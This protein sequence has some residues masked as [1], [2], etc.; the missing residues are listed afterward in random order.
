[1][2]QR[3]AGRPAWHMQPPTEANC[4]PT[5]GDDQSHC[6]KGGGHVVA[7]PGWPAGLGEVGRPHMEAP[8]ARVWRGNQAQLYYLLSTDATCSN[9][10][11]RPWEGYK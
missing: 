11:N 7:S 10:Q 2:G 3:E 6:P 9:R 1:M 5:P 8:Q 4:Q